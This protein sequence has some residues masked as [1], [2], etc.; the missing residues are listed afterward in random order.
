MKDSMASEM[1][2]HNLEKGFMSSNSFLISVKGVNSSLKKH[3]YLMLV[4]ALILNLE[5]LAIHVAENLKHLGLE[6]S[7]LEVSISKLQDSIDLL[8]KLELQTSLAL[9]SC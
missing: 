9:S 6:F 4:K 3:L 1:C 5:Q 8:M 7:W 2:L